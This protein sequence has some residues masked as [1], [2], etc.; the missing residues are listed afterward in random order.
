MIIEIQGG[1]LS[2]IADALKQ[3]DND[4]VM[5]HPTMARLQSLHAAKAFAQ[6]FLCVSL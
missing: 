5:Q 3:K 4:G 1:G 2:L 6:V